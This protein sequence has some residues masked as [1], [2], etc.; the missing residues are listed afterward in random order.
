LAAN[1]SNV[2]SIVAIRLADSH[3]FETSLKRLKCANSGR[4]PA[5]R[6]IGQNARSCHSGSAR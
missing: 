2:I 6:Q 5:A 3:R 1:P 4:W